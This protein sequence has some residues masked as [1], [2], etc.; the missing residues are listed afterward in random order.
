MKVRRAEAMTQASTVETIRQMAEDARAQGDI[1]RELHYLLAAANSIEGTP[2]DWLRY[3][4]RLEANGESNT[5]ISIA[6]TLTRIHPNIPLFHLKLSSLL[7]N[8]GDYCAAYEKTIWCLK[9]SI[10]PDDF[11]LQYLEAAIMCQIYG[12]YDDPE[13]LCY[14]IQEWYQQFLKQNPLQISNIPPRQSDIIN[15]GYVNNYFNVFL[16][17][18]TSLSVIKNHQMPNLNV[19]CYNLSAIES[20]RPHDLPES[21]NFRSIGHFS[22]DEIVKIIQ[23]DHIDI[24]ID[25]NGF[26][27]GNRWKVYHQRP[28]PIMMS[29][30]NVFSPMGGT[31]FDY[32]VMDPVLSPPDMDRFFPEKIARLPCWITLDPPT[33]APA[34]TATPA[35]TGQGVTFGCFNR[36]SKLNAQV[37]AV[38]QRI[39][40]KVPGSRLYLRNSSYSDS[41]A[42]ERVEILLEDAGIDL[43]SVRIEGWS[44]RGNF[45]AA[46]GE[47]DILLDPFP[48]NGG[49][50]SLE[51]MWQGLPMVALEG[52]SWGARLGA[53]ILTGANCREWLARS[54]DEYVDIAVRLAADPLKL[55]D[56]RQNLRLRLANSA[57]MDGAGAARAMEALFQK[58]IEAHSPAGHRAFAQEPR[59]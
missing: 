8:H 16:Y 39:L 37:M 38:W 55:D 25:M 59:S 10:V 50:T 22:D 48:F 44:D 35:L 23:Q 2:E 42:R 46:Y 19:F 24:L 18:Q 13:Q 5:A 40:A 41:Y 28:A 56:I 47:A 29:W 33:T 17:H 14:L 26:D 53:M 52:R 20:E 43:D 58:A 36:A 3:F 57:I 54:E 32:I 34:V 1:Q 49:I 31:M 12:P 27:M 6:N 9:Q 4:S 7:F 21:I 15:I 11:I 51:A 45:I 30:Y